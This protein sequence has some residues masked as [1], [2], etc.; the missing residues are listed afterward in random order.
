MVTMQTDRRSICEQE[1]GGVFDLILIC[2]QLLTLS[3][4]VSHT[5]THTL[6][7]LYFYLFG[8]GH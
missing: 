1:W 7:G 2:E 6:K 3:I 4:S 5:H 8:D